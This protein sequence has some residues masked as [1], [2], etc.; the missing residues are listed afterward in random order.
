MRVQD[1]CRVYGI[2]NIS[3]GLSTSV[4][5]SPINN[6]AGIRVGATGGT[7]QIAGVTGAWTTGLP[8]IASTDYQTFSVAGAPVLY[9]TAAGAT[10]VARV[11][12]YL[13]GNPAPS[14]I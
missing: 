8:F 2:T 11:E 5:I 13:T 7:M 3:V 12:Y 6:Q 1:E 4:Q 14:N 10:C 9:L